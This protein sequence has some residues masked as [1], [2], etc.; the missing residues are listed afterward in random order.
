MQK[1]LGQKK[2]LPSKSV[3][4]NSNDLKRFVGKKVTEIS[5]EDEEELE[6]EKEE[7]EEDEIADDFYRRE[8]ELYK[9]WAAVEYRILPK[10][11]WRNERTD[12]MKTTQYEEC[13]E[14]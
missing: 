8:M 1:P 13:F 5:E 9:K 11:Y 7:E 3:V 2:Q 10:Q 12:L 4:L 6:E 14:D